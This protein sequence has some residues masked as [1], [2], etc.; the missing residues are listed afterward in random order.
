MLASFQEQLLA[1]GSE[2][3]QRNLIKRL[4][5]ES[6]GEEARAVL[7]AVSK[8]GEASSYRIFIVALCSGPKLLQFC[9]LCRPRCW[10][11]PVL[12]NVYRVLLTPAFNALNRCLSLTSLS[13]VRGRLAAAWRWKRRS[14]GTGAA[15]AS[16][17][18]LI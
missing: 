15:Q 14:A 8:V 2:K 6:G 9:S 5:A 4:L 18:D 12:R 7:S 10:D 3:E 1:I 11:R 16:R 13:R 17:S